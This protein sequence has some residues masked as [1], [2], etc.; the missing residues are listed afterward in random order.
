MKPVDVKGVVKTL[1]LCFSDRYPKSKKS[2]FCQGSV[3]VDGE[4]ILTLNPKSESDLFNFY[5]CHFYSV[6]YTDC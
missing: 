4:N 5:C 2:K 1:S 6:G 3:D